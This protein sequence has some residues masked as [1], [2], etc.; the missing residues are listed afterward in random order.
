MLGQWKYK[1]VSISKGQIKNK[2]IPN[3]IYELMIVWGLCTSVSVMK[4][5][6]WL[7]GF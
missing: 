3:P 6:C 5:C 1:Y 4:I 7:F 2:V